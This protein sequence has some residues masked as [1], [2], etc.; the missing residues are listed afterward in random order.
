MDNQHH[1]ISSVLVIELM[2]LN[3]HYCFYDMKIFDD[4]GF[5]VLLTHLLQLPLTSVTIIFRNSNNPYNEVTEVDIV[6]AVV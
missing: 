3:N 5:T 2:E 1:S 4:D 6:C